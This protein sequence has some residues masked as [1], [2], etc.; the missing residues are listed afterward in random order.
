MNTTLND[1]AM[2]TV[3]LPTSLFFVTIVSDTEFDG[4]PAT[5]AAFVSLMDAAKFAAIIR[6][7]ANE[8]IIVEGPDGIYLDSSIRPIALLND[9]ILAHIN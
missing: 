2:E 3:G 6:P 8:T 1:L 9:R 7:N 4:A 5:I